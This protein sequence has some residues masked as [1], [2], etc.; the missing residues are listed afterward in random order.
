MPTSAA[1]GTDS[2][3]T[4]GK[5]PKDEKPKSRAV[6]VDPEAPSPPQDKPVVPLADPNGNGFVQS[7]K[8]DGSIKVYDAAQKGWEDKVFEGTTKA[9]S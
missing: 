9:G 3:R 7:V 1:T 5:T 6:K 4:A 2:V 8:A